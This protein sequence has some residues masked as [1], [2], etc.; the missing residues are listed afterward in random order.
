MLRTR[1]VGL[2]CAPGGPSSKAAR[3]ESI[4]AAESAAG[5]SLVLLLLLGMLGAAPPPAAL[6][7]LLYA[8][9]A[10]PALA[11]LTTLAD[12]AGGDMGSGESTL[13]LQVVVA[14][15]LRLAAAAMLALAAAV[16]MPAAA[17]GVT[18]VGVALEPAPMTP[19][20][21]ATPAVREDEGPFTASRGLGIGGVAGG[22]VRAT[23]CFCLRGPAGLL[24][25][26][27]EHCA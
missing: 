21:A 5:S 2:R 13:T 12:F 27:R 23:R 25:T 10:L 4:S 1:L 14:A 15:V 6:P 26:L 11:A 8:L 7:W 3:C 22:V 24:M 9:P 18:V 20:A 16:A 17:R 19:G